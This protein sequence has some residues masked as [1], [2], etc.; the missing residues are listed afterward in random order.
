[1]SLN[2]TFCPP[3]ASRN[4][5]MSHMLATLAGRARLSGR[6]RS[7]LH[8]RARHHGRNR[9]DE[10]V[11]R[12]D[13]ALD[14]VAQTQSCAAPSVSPD[15]IA[16][17][18]MPRPPSRS[19]HNTGVL[20]GA[21]SWDCQ[22]MLRRR[23]GG[24]Q[25]ARPARV[26]AWFITEPPRGR[27]RRRTTMKTLK[28]LRGLRIGLAAFALAVS[29]LAVSAVATGQAA[30]AGTEECE[31]EGAYCLRVGSGDDTDVS[32]WME[33]DKGMYRVGEEVV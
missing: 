28:T 10:L 9:R 5:P 12:A 13:V 11:R 26:H 8:F 18:A 21:G 23:S 30:H 32:V 22:A 3:R 4:R 27:A 29:A 33:P 7:W 6:V 2:V 17:A 31:D 25:D 16:G 14:A 15:L 20:I 1:M 19:S 24:R